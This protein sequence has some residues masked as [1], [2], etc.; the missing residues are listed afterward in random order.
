MELKMDGLGTTS[1]T[2]RVKIAM[3][4]DLYGNLLTDKQREAMDMYFQQ[5]F[6][7]SEIS[8]QSGI[9]RQGVWDNIKRGENALL[10]TEKKLGLVEKFE[11]IRKTLT[12]VYSDA[13]LVKLYA[14]QKFLPADIIKSM[15]KILTA[16]SNIVE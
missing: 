14:Q 5:D 1:E 7:L 12:S 15:D 11:E 13:V 16:I 6:T 8:E 10:E 9:T 4:L 2:E 3:L